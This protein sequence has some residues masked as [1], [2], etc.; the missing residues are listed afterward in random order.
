MDCVKMAENIA[1]RFRHPRA[2]SLRYFIPF[3]NLSLMELARLA[4][5]L[6]D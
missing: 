3:G 5:D 1:R 2:P 4:L 6:V